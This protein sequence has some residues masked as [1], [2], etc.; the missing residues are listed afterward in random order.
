MKTYFIA[1]ASFVFIHYKADAQTEI[2]LDSLMFTSEW[3]SNID[4]AKSNPEKVW[5]LD[6][7]LQKLKVFPK[8]IIE[9]KNVKQLYLQANYWPSIPNEIGNLKQVE[10]I[11]IS[12]NYYLKVLPDGLQNCTSLKQLI[13][14][15]NK[16]NAGEVARIKKLLF[17][18][19][20]I[21]E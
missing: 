5:F 12:S 4:D 17:N 14:K 15:D 2:K 7:G 10:I 18:V 9:F 3:F 11:D 6:L 20:V 21:T 8:E 19:K 16:L 1:I 13:L